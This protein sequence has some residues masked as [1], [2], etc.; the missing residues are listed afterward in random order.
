M[1][2]QLTAFARADERWGLRNHVL[3]LPLHS[4]LCATARKIAEEVKNTI[5]LKKIDELIR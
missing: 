4:A 3:I 1:S 5:K 2:N